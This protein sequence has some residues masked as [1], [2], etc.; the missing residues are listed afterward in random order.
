MLSS[1]CSAFFSPSIVVHRG[2]IT[3][4]GATVISAM[5]EGKIAAAGMDGWL[6][7]DGKWD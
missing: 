2:D 7:T 4:D 1:G 3:S 5:D 6:N